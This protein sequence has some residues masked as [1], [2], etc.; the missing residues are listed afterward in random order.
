MCPIKIV[1][2]ILMCRMSPH[3]AVTNPGGSLRV[4]SMRLHTTP[5]P[6]CFS[7]IPVLREN[8]IRPRKNF[9]GPHTVSCSFVSFLCLPLLCLDFF[10][11]LPLV[12]T[13]L[14][15]LGAFYNSCFKNQSLMDIFKHVFQN[16]TDVY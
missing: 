13:M 3:T 12:L 9:Y 11:I 14:A 10:F 8:S 5:S 7:H 4:S 16:G 1:P 2:C 6:S 15:F